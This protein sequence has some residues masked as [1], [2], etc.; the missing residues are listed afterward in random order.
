MIYGRKL[1]QIVR[2]KRFVP[3]PLVAPYN[4]EAGAVYW[5]GYWQQYYTV[6]KVDGR[7]VKVRWEDEK[8]TIHSTSLNPALDYQLKGMEFVDIAIPAN[9]SLTFAEIKAHLVI[10]EQFPS[11]VM[12]DF[13]SRYLRKARCPNDVAYYYLCF[14]KDKQKLFL[15]RDLSKSP[16]SAEVGRMR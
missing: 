3:Y 2:E 5:C 4:Y 14:D 10:G 16:R 9:V 11:E 6:I 15:N 1:T 13:E 8:E 7:Q 12:F